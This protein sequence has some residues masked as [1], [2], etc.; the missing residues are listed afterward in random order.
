VAH[1]A[2]ELSPRTLSDLFEL[3]LLELLA[4]TG[5]RH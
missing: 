3:F 4:D 2:I 1:G 5:R